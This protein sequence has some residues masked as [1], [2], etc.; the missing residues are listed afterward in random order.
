M[1]WTFRTALL[2][3]ACAGVLGVVPAWAQV[4]GPVDFTT[5]FPFAVGATTLPAGQYEIRPVDQDPG[6][7]RIEM[8]NGTNGAFFHAD[9]LAL[10]SGSATEVVFNEAHGKYALDRIEVAG[11][12]GAVVPSS[13]PGVQQASTTPKTARHVKATHHHGKK[14]GK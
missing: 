9:P 5:A 4:D 6:M 8:R 2:T 14:A 13:G 11:E 12:E 1:R 7:Y 3:G 10:P